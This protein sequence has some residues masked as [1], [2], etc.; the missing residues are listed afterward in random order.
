MRVKYIN[1]NFLLYF[2]SKLILYSQKKNLLIPSFYN[3]KFNSIQNY[4]IY[5][6]S[7]KWIIRM[8][9]QITRV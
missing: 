2:T 1:F 3:E 5:I 9:Y 8:Y 6:I 4:I 7:V